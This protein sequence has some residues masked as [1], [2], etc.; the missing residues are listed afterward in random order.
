MKKHII[1]IFVMFSQI[2]SSY[3]SAQSYLAIKDGNVWSVLEYG[4]ILGQNDNGMPQNQICCINTEQTVI[5][6][7]SVVNGTVY[8]KIF[9]GKQT[10]KLKFEG[11]LREENQKVFFI[12]EN[13]FTESVL[14]NFSVE[15]GNWVQ[16]TD[17]EGYSWDWYAQVDNVDINGV[18]KKRIQLSDTSESNLI[19]DTWLE[20]IGSLHGLLN[21]GTLP[22][23]GGRQLLCVS[24]GEIVIYQDTNFEECY[25]GSKDLKT[26]GDILGLPVI[27][28]LQS[29]QDGR[30]SIEI[31]KNG[32]IISARG[33][34]LSQIEIFNMSGQ[35]VCVTKITSNPVE[36]NTDFLTHGVYFAK[37]KEDDNQFYSF[38]FIKR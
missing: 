15:S 13:A 27:T 2:Y 16:F 8:N 31:S 11:L 23:G 9:S 20:G 30:I 18:M 10:E 19:F 34:I 35:K 4:L 5:K 22:N 33:E 7:D 14:Y 25:Y 38:K 29:M 24:E 17:K 32:I 6:G 37:I 26:V 36:I 21:V 28:G 3:L 1:F 12:P